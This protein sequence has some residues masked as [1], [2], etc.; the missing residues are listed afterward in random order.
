V[1]TFELIKARLAAVR[2]F[3][4]ILIV[5]V[6]G[7]IKSPSVSGVKWDKVSEGS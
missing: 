6:S 3:E 4:N 7:A 2:H 1:K 5:I